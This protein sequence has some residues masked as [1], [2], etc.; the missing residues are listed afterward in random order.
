MRRRG[1]KRNT[2]ASRREKREGGRDV[3]ERGG[4][5]ARELRAFGVG[6]VAGR[7]GL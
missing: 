3:K 2:Q 4:E 5:R 1:L 7:G 6:R